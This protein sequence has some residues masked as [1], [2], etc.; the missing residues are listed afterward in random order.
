MFKIIEPQDHI[1]YKHTIHAF[2]NLLKVSQN[3]DVFL[4]EKHSQ[5]KDST[6]FI[7]AGDERRGV[8]GGA[9]LYR[10]PVSLLY[11]KMAKVILHF[12]SERQEVWSGML[13]LRVEDDES[14][15]TLNTL[16]LHQNFYLNLYKTF[17]EFGEKKDLD[18]LD[19]T[20]CSKD[21]YNIRTYGYWPYLL[22]V[23]PM[24]SPDSCFHGLLDVSHRKSKIFN[25]L[26]HI[27]DL[28]I[29]RQVP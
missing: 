18:F 2:L 22:E 12:Q 25:S 11:E 15:F 4:K 17:V 7:I 9:A 29:H 16:D 5:I 21:Y 13:C 24:D 3:C 10:Q 23:Q 20:L 19:L 28:S 1:F 26:Q 14:V 27:P 8:Y 6:T